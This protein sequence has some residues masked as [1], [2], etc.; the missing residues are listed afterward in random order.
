[1]F[2]PNSMSQCVLTPPP[3]PPPPMTSVNTNNRPNAEEI[4]DSH[5]VVLRNIRL[6]MPPRVRNPR[7]I[8]G[9][10]GALTL[11]QT[12]PILTRYNKY[13]IS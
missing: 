12:R 3:S 6:D 9:G 10:G 5:I 2:W 11:F 1:M 7:K 8:R 13:E 4:D